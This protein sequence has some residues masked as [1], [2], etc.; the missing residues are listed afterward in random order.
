MKKRN[1]IL[2]GLI[3]LLGFTFFYPIKGAE[4]IKYIERSSGIVKTEK[5]AGEFWL[6]WLYNN[7][8]GKLSLHTLV[9]RK[10]VSEWYGK[11]MDSP[12]SA[13]KI[14]DF[15]KDYNIDLSI[16]QKQEFNSFNDFFCRKLKPQARPI[17]N[18][19]NVVISP[20]DGKVFA[21]KNIDK[22]DFIV[23]SY[24]FNLKDFLLNDSLAK[25]YAGGSLIIVRLCP[26]DYHRYHFP[27]SGI[28]DKQT[29]IDGDYYSVSPIAIK[30]KIE[31]FCMNKRTYTEIHTKTFGDVI[32]SEVGAT[33]VGSII[34]T[35]ND[36]SVTK[37]EEKG[38][39]KFG[40][41]TV[42]LFFEKNRITIDK[43]LL[44]NT[45]NKIETEV[46][47]G[48]HIAVAKQ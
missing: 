5:V 18:D 43:D 17:N 46:K 11:K 31:I 34:Q 48:E 35:Y 9:R 32:Y 14:P 45:N 15:V 21:Y 40:G 2:L 24:K 47:M 33:M 10:A 20:A 29:D 26:T 4:P 22:Q 41:S 37:G 7:P 30:H 12:K 3:I 16:A 19:S 44:E 38:Y 25:K 13:N 27:V 36:N 23:K 1:K 39:F 28:V 42:I 8:L 6:S